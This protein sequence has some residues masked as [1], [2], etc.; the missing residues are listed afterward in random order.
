MEQTVAILGR[1][2]QAAEV[3]LQEVFE[4]FDDGEDRSDT[5]VLDAYGRGAELLHD[6]E[7]TLRERESVRWYDL[8]NRRRPA[9]LFQFEHH[10][11]LDR[12]LRRVLDGLSKVLEF[13]PAQEARDLAREQWVELASHGRAGLGSLLKTLKDLDT[14]WALFDSVEQPSGYEELVEMLSFALRF[15]AVYSLSEAPDP[16][17]LHLDDGS[18]LV[19]FEALAEHFEPVEHKTVRWMLDAVVQDAALRYAARDSTERPDSPPTIVHLYARPPM[20][21]SIAPW[22]VDTTGEVRHVAVFQ[23]QGRNSLSQVAGA[24]ARKAGRTL[25][26]GPVEAI[27]RETH[28]TWLSREGAEEVESL[29]DGEVWCRHNELR[30]TSVTE[31]GRVEPGAHFELFRT[32]LEAGEELTP[33]RQTSAVFSEEESPIQDGLYRELCQFERLRLGWERVKEGNPHSNGADE[34]T[35]REFSQDADRRLRELQEELVSRTYQCLPLVRVD[36][37]KSGD[38]TRPLGICAVRD[39]VVQTAALDLLEP[40][41]E[42]KFSQYSFAFRPRRN[43]RQAVR[44]AISFLEEGYTWAV[45][46]DIRK[47]FESLDHDRLERILA[48]YIQDGDMLSLLKQWIAPDVLQFDTIFPT[49]RGVEQGMPLAPLLANLYLHSLDRF[50]ESLD[51][52][53]LRYADDLLILSESREEASEVLDETQTF[54]ETK[55]GMS[56]NPGKTRVAPAGEGI[57]YL[58]FVLHPTELKIQQSRIEETVQKARRWLRHIANHNSSMLERGKTIYRLD[59][60]IRGFRNYFFLEDAPKVMEGLQE[61][62]ERVEKMARKIL[63]YDV[64]R[65]P[66]WQGREQFNPD[67]PLDEIDESSGPYSGWEVDETNHPPRM[68]PPP[69]SSPPVEQLDP[70]SESTSDEK[71]TDSS[72]N[73]R[74]ESVDPEE[75]AAGDVF[76]EEDGRLFVLKHG[77]FLTLRRDKVVVCYKREEIAEFEPA[78]VQLVFV[79]GFGI[80]ITASLQLRLA[81]LDVPLVIAPHG[82][83]IPAV[84]GSLESSKA[85][86]RRLQAIRRDD[87]DVRKAARDIVSAKLAN[88]ASVLRYFEK[89]RRSSAPDVA[90][91]L[92]RAADEIRD[93]EED[94]SNVPVEADKYR[95][96]LMGHEGRAAAVYWEAYAEL[97]PDDCEFESRRGREAEDVVNNCLNLV[98]ALLYAEVWRAVARSGLDPYFGILHGSSRD[99]GSL[100]FDL[101]EEFRAPFGDRVLVAMFGRNFEPQIRDDG[102][103]RSATCRKLVE[104]FRRRWTEETS[105][106]PEAVTPKQILDEQVRSFARFVQRAE[107]Y[108]PFRMK[109]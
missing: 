39:R 32:R 27:D 24:W 79:H 71:E 61:L 38:D 69:S 100:V 98:Y 47:C 66:S 30:R 89:Y 31:L 87:D 81:E 4:T 34:V 75:A 108:R 106:H 63:P 10:E 7:T 29:S 62:D 54:L 91:S 49:I 52:K 83:R 23:F 45:K 44:L 28:G 58:G 64:L 8:A 99:A 36:V 78:T 90:Q 51:V 56:L 95:N 85:D 60:L 73:E 12:I 101:I 96:I 22:I 103:L 104:G 37:P 46:S 88:Q 1:S 11:Q 67:V 35:I 57:D 19:W 76:V 5:V 40:L 65:D 59:G 74:E 84:S 93:V 92:K 41:F 72:E 102:T 80:T 105:F 77:S 97:L 109:W 68:G 21:T 50:L 55:L 16:A 86:L 53:F 107:S 82:K 18:E 13:G 2:W 17:N 26:A 20:Q 42:P 94:V 14:R 70:D 9:A 25:V 48:R 15:P 3:A 43:A 6:R 33:V